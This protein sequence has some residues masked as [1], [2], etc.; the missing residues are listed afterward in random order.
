MQLSLIWPNLRPTFHLKPVIWDLMLLF[1][2]FILHFLSLQMVSC[3]A[4]EF[5][6]L[7]SCVEDVGSYMLFPVDFR[8][9]ASAQIR[10]HNLERELSLVIC[11]LFHPDGI[12]FFLFLFLLQ[13]VGGTQS[14]SWLHP[15]GRSLHLTKLSPTPL[16]LKSTSDFAS[17]LFSQWHQYHYGYFTV[18][19]MVLGPTA[20][21]IMWQ[22]SAWSASCA[23]GDDCT[24][25]ALV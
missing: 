10:W 17:V 23:S 5:L 9:A 20:M 24:S 8:K 25:G 13:V 12:S 18:W 22:C 21:M 14:L 16:N 4:A 3:Q 15:K 2:T 7:N 6:Y 19:Q 1:H 11:F